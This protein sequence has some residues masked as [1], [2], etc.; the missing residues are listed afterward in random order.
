VFGQDADSCACT[1]PF[2]LPL[3]RLASPQDRRRHRRPDPSLILVTDGFP[4]W[5]TFPFRMSYAPPTAAGETVLCH[6]I[7]QRT[8]NADPFAI[9]ITDHAVYIPR[10]KLFAMRDPYFF[11]R[12]PRDEVI[13]WTIA[14]AA[15]WPARVLGA[16]LTV[17]GAATAWIMFGQIH[18]LGAGKL[19]VLPFFLVGVGLTI[20]FAARARQ[21]LAI[22]AAAGRFVWTWPM[23]VNRA[24]QRELA[25]LFAQI[26]AAF[27]RSGFP[28]SDA[29]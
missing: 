5:R 19:Y 12:W 18:D 26:R 3:P 28:D 6:G 29:G 22:R 27:E 23:S 7:F 1:L 9:C 25:T 10:K 20:A 14:P 21:R 24:Q 8:A 17:V 13:G 11:E 4:A 16:T 15:P 2:L